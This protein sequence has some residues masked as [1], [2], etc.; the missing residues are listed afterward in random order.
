MAG[1][2][3]TCMGNSYIRVVLTEILLG[4]IH[5]N[6]IYSFYVVNMWIAMCITMCMRHLLSG[7]IGKIFYAVGSDLICDGL[8]KIH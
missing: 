6:F 2:F 4:K 5:L 7:Y 8:H 1:R 3:T